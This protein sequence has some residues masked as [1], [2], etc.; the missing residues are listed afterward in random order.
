MWLIPAAIWDWIQDLTR[1]FVETKTPY[2]SFAFATA[3]HVN[4][5]AQ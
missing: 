2:T 4:Y 1:L 3:N 5:R